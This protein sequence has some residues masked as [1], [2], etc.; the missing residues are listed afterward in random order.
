MPK[1]FDSFTMLRE[2]D[3][4]KKGAPLVYDRRR[5]EALSQLS[6]PP[7]PPSPTKCFYHS[8]ARGVEGVFLAREKSGIQKFRVEIVGGGGERKFR[9]NSKA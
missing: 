9:G 1:Y 5:E 6:P 2:H 7:P 3:F 4:V 8:N